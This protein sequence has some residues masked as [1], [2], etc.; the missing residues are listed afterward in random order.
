MRRD[1]STPSAPAPFGKPKGDDI[2]KAVHEILGSE[3]LPHQAS[4]DLQTRTARRRRALRAYD[5]HRGADSESVAEARKGNAHADLAPALGPRVL[6]VAADPHRGLRLCGH[7]G[8][9]PA[10]GRQGLP[11]APRVPLYPDRVAQ[12]RRRR[13]V[14]RQGHGRE[15]RAAERHPKG[16][17]NPKQ[18]KREGLLQGWSG[19]PP[20]RSIPDPAQIAPSHS[21]PSSNPPLLPPSPFSL[22]LPPPSSSF[23]LPRLLSLLLGLALALAPLLLRHGLARGSQG[24]EGGPRDEPRCR[25]LERGHPPGALGPVLSLTGLGGG[26]L[27]MELLLAHPRRGLDGPVYQSRCRGFV[28]CGL[29]L[30]GAGQSWAVFS[31]EQFERCAAKDVGNKENTWEI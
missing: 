2:G 26:E 5:R 3:A 27:A 22:L 23:L 11:G 9:R 8:P 21:S 31:K 28:M 4:Q 19:I 24:R 7:P 30:A 17:G 10:P 13:G 18:T 12:K 6:L 14:D 16:A 1:P 29:D 15:G 25:P 20:S